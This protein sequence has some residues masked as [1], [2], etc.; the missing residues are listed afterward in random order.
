V[1][2]GLNTWGWWCW[3]RAG[4]CAAWP[5]AACGARR[6]DVVAPLLLKQP[7]VPGVTPLWRES[8]VAE[9]G[10]W[11]AR[12]RRALPRWMVPAGLDGD[13]GWRAVWDAV[14]AVVR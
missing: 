6:N 7:L 11:C 1:V 10:L 9:P 2:F 3:W 5:Q 12:L 8:G 14:A 4:A 13:A